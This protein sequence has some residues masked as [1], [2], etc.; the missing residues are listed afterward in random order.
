M[1]VLKKIIYN[2]TAPFRETRQRRTGDMQSGCP[3]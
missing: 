3:G 2:F 1:L